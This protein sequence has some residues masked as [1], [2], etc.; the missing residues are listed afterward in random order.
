MRILSLHTGAFGARGGIGAYNR[1]MVAAWCSHPRVTEV[2]GLAL[3]KPDEP[4]G[5]LPDNLLWMAHFDGSRPKFSA[6]AVGHAAFAGPWDLVVC[7]HVNFMPVAAAAGLAAR[8]PVLLL[9]YG[10]D[11]WQRHASRLVNESLRAANAVCSISQI[12]LDKMESWHPL[13]GKRS[14]ICPNAVHPD[15]FGAG[16]K[17]QKLIDRY[18]LA[19]R[20]VLL[21]VAR[22]NSLERYKG[23]DEVI[24][25][26]PKLKQSYP[27]LLYLV[28][29]DGDDR[30]RLEAKAAR[31]GV[32]DDVVFAGYAPD[33]EL[34]DHYRVA[35]AFVMPGSGEGFGFVYLEA[36][37]CGI[38][39]VAS[40]VDGSRE[41]VRDG[42]LGELVDPHDLDDIER[43]TRAVLDK[44]RSEVPKE[45]SY[46]YW[47]RFEQRCHDML[48]ALH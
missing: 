29:G 16:A 30:P 22:L 37:A 4:I 45:L 7:G 36:L 8:A 48:D 2:V 46:F 9:V 38:P 13:D 32:K 40:K 41:A 3:Q 1:D 31:L 20:R 6:T 27:S 11:V 18:G 35:D 12:T 24:E 19:G 47:E 42:L 5:E 14:F 26:M 17:P 23:I 15:A 21:T 34:A 39:V 28:V 25:L 33:G 10:V 43:A 44:G